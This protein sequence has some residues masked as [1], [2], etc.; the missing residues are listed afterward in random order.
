M[1][2]KIKDIF[3][4]RYAALESKNIRLADVLSGE[5]FSVSGIAPPNEEKIFFRAEKTIGTGGKKVVLLCGGGR[6]MTA[7]ESR[8]CKYGCT[9]AMLAVKSAMEAENIN[10]TVKLIYCSDKRDNIQ[11]RADCA[12]EWLASDREM[13]AVDFRTLSEF[14]MMFE[15]Y[16][17][18]SHASAA[19]WNGRSALDAVSLMDIGT[20]YLREHLTRDSRIRYA[21]KNG[22]AAANI[23]PEYASVLYSIAACREN[24]D[25]LT[26]RIVSVAK[27]AEL[28]TGTRMQATVM[29]NIIGLEPDAAITELLKKNMP[30]NERSAAEKE[31][32]RKIVIERPILCAGVPSGFLCGGSP[33][34]AFGIISGAMLDAFKISRG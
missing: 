34:K 32:Y 26:E 1:E 31:E 30:P 14:R 6:D 19:P 12:F 17:I 21:V 24:I 11:E 23:V 4:E 8:L 18:P 33:R 5:G 20:A 29:D 9:A 2:N 25:E 22:G 28:M 7:E 3:E 27:G 16:G 10:G 13:E 15:F